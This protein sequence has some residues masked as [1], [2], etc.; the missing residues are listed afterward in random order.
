MMLEPTADI[1]FD[2][3]S[4]S[5]SLLY[6]KLIEDEETKVV[7]AKR[8]FFLVLIYFQVRE[9]K[10][11]ARSRYCLCIIFIYINTKAIL[12]TFFLKRNLS[13]GVALK[14]HSLLL[15]K[16]I[17]LNIFKITNNIFDHEHTATVIEANKLFFLKL[18][19]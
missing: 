1:L 11:R 6:I 7:Y 14:W 16:L 12:Y 17:G 2:L 19:K 4:R 13:I 10:K 5:L 18:N 8:F 15:N 9:K 3:K